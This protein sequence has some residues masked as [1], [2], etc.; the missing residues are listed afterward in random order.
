MHWARPT[1]AAGDEAV[2]LLS[3]GDRRRT[4]AYGRRGRRNPRTASRRSSTTRATLTRRRAQSPGRSRSGGTRAQR[5]PQPARRLQPRVRLLH[6]GQQG[7]PG[8]GAGGLPA[9]AD[10]GRRRAL[11]H[12]A[13]QGAR[14]AHRRGARGDRR[15]RG[16]AV[17]AGL[18]RSSRASPTVCAVWRTLVGTLDVF[19]ALAEVAARQGFVRPVID[20]GDALSIRDGRHPVV[21]RDLRRR[22]LRAQRH[23]ARFRRRA[24]RRAHRT[25]HGRQ[26]DLP[27]TG[28][29]DRAAGA[30]R[31]L[32]AGRERRRSASSTASSP[33]SAPGRPVARR[34][35]LHGRDARDR[36][37]PAQRHP[38]LARALRRG[39]ARHQ[40]LRR[41]RD[42]ARGRRVPAR[43]PGARRQDAVRDALP[44]DDRSS[45]TRCRACATSA[46][47]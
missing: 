2:A 27:A 4:G 28:R 12:A 19:S 32:R 15:A 6:R 23:R 40:H 21:E 7:Q 35:D 26:V 10:A 5:H 22:T 44:R 11:R 31:Q 20:D 29:A 30:G 45:R 9:Q 38:T 46:S 41:P 43:P 17:P 24:D 8:A 14:G 1:V 39:R 13:S 3:G 16:V 34:I 47:R 42:R 25:E 18:S 36:G 33:A 37:D